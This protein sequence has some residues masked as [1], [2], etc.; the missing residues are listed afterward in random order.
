MIKEW[1][2]ADSAKDQEVHQYR[3][4]NIALRNRL[5]NQHKVLRKK[6]QLADGLHLIDF[7]QLKIENQTL[8]EKIEERNDELSKLRAKIVANVIILS[9]NREKYQ[10]IMKQNEKQQKAL[11]NLDTL[12]KD[13]K[14]KLA[15]ETKKLKKKLF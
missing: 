14:E 3:L 7:E 2:D 12:L 10:F 8:N 6:E 13:N 5:A 9:H 15:S 1:E 11:S 4:Q